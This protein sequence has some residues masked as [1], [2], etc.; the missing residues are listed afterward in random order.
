MCDRTGSPATHLGR[1]GA[2]RTIGVG[3]PPSCATA[4][5]AGFA[6]SAACPR[7]AG[8]RARA[9]R[10]APRPGRRAR[11]GR[12]PRASAPPRPSSATSTTRRLVARRVARTTIASRRR[13][14]ARSRAPRRR[15]STRP[16]RPARAAARRAAR[17]SSTSTGARRASAS[18]RGAR[19]RSERT[20][21]CRP[22]ASSR[23]S[24]RPV[25]ELVDRELEQLG[26]SSAT[27]AAGRAEQDGGEPLLRAVVQVALD[28]L[29]LVVGDLDEP[30]AGGAQL[31]A[32]PHAL[33]DVAQVAGED[34]RPGERDPRDRQLDGELGAVAAHP[35]ELEPPVEDLPARSVSRKRASPAGVLA[36]RLGGTISSA[37]SR[38]IASLGW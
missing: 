21:G 24:W 33:G 32:R 23:I 37:M 38:P 3:K 7:H 36:R 27:R 28:A 1:H 14:S 22:L 30:R 13:A 15:R 9:S 29:P 26:A 25:G 2:G 4:I 12:C 35:G 34:R 16:P 11:A 18:Q 6:R 20:G 19:P 17:A 10:R 5:R 8:C 31:L